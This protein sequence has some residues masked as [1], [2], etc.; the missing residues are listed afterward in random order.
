MSKFSVKKPFTVLVG[1]IM[2]LVLGYVSFTK[3]T[4]DLLPEMSLPYM[5]VISTYPGATP[6]KV[7]SEVTEV[8]ESALGTVNG[9]ENVTSTSNENYG[10]VMLEFE[11]GTNMDSAMVKVSSAINQLELPETVGSPVIYELSPDMMPTLEVGIDY[12]GKDIYDLSRFTEDTIVPFLE[13]QNGVASVSETGVVEKTVEIRL[14]QKKIDKL[15]HKLKDEVEEKMDDAQ[16]ELDEASGKLSDAKKELKQKQKELKQQQEETAGELG[17]A[18]LQMSE[19]ISIKNA[20]SAQLQ[21]LQASKIALETEKKAYEDAGVIEGY[22]GINTAFSTILDT[23]DSDEVYQQIY[24]PVYNMVRLEAA[25]A[26]VS[27]AGIQMVVTEENLDGI[28]SMLGDEAAAQ[29]NEAAAAQ[30]D[31]ITKQKIQEQKDSVPTDIQDA[32]ANPSKLKSVKKM[33]EEQGQEDA[34]KN[35]TVKKLSQM[36]EIVN[37]RIPQIDTE[38]ANLEIEIKAAEAVTNQVTSMTSAATENYGTLESGKISAA[39]GFGSGDAQMA[40]GLSSIETSEKQL[41]ESQDTLDEA[42]KNALEQANLDT[43]LDMDTLS[44]LISAQNFEMPAGYIY[45]GENQYMLKVGEEYESEK[46]MEDMLLCNVD[47]IGDVRISDVAY[48][49]WIDNAD[50]SYAKINKNNAVL[51]SVSKSSTAGTSEVSKACNKAMEELE[52]E[53]PGLH[54]TSLFDQGDYIKLIINSVLSNLIYGAILAIIVLALFLQDV[55]PTIVVAFSIPLSVLF[56]IVLMYFSNISMNI[57]SLSGLALGV[58][59]LVDNSIVVIENIYRMRSEGV[60]A[61]RAAVRGAEQVAGAIFA[62]TLTTICVFLPI[63]FTGGMTRDLFEDMALTITYSLTASLIVALTFVP[64]MS[65]TVLRQN[66]ER[67]HRFFHA[68]QTAYEKILRFCLKFK[69]VPI[70]VSIALLAFCGYQ[71]TKIGMILIPSMGGN[72]MSITVEAPEE[73]TEEEAY[74]LADQVM[75]QFMYID[76]VETVGA[77][78]GGMTSLSIGGSSSKTFTFMAILNE[79]AAKDNSKI[80]TQMEDILSELP[81]EEFSVSTSNMDMSSMMASGMQINIYGQENERLLEISRDV[82]DILGKVEGFENISNGQEEGDVQ[83]QVVIDK[84]KAMRKGLTV[85]QIFSELSSNLKT[86]K[87]STTLTIDGEGYNVVIADDSKELT[88]SNLMDYEFT[89]TSKDDDGKDVEEKHQLSEFAKIEEK[90]GLA[91]ISRENQTRYISVTAETKDGYNTTLLSRD[92]EKLI[93][94]YQVPDGYE[95]KISGESSSVNETMIELLK[96]IGLAVIFI[97]LI[98]VAQFQ[99]LFS[100]FIVLFTIPLAFTGGFLALLAVGEE[101]S[102][103]SMMG[104]LVLAGVVVNNG[105]VFVDYANQLRLEGME[106]KE[107]LIETGKTRMRPIFMTAL[108]T[109]LA[110]STMALS[111]DASAAMGRGMAVVTMGGL[112]YATLMTL[113]IIPVLYDIVFRKGMKKIEID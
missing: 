82:M 20:Y 94:E 30:A 67:K 43:L 51:L 49:T 40:S 88:K 78:S 15:N 47:G 85:A 64:A 89:T 104:F 28:L 80:A 77:M 65:S 59:M 53:Y 14:D 1:V 84:D 38:L 27:G 60:P 71:V 19:A 54:F 10:M 48:V 17:D 41:E 11:E 102:I 95:V 31:E 5:M 26:A 24:Q 75:D 8:L 81:C 45:E 73:S 90:E 23:L 79:E 13:R 69:F 42:R 113:F 32:I 55:R 63:V 86:E 100:P 72:Q 61:P 112:A 108:T 46:D 36:D 70:L 97:Y 16:K 106:K 74:T 91:S 109:I 35:L 96:M 57:I 12:E 93:D 3:L 101:L 103:T 29:I 7:E 4:T 99:N 87:D 111:T 107:A 50:D 110:M 22:Q 56:A 68:I 58:G 76:G 52:E 25:K 34:A 33:M 39:A 21:G 83:L 62:S 2:I 9:V 105:I 92:V 98:M 66:K 37:T 44:Q 18:S 6:E